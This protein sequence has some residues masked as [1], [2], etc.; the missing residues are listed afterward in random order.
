MDRIIRFARREVF[1]DGQ[2]FFNRAVG[3]IRVREHFLRV[4]GGP[5]KVTVNGNFDKT[6]ERGDGARRPYDELLQRRRR[7]FPLGPFRPVRGR[8]VD[9][10]QGGILHVRRG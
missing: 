9:E 8:H 2:T 1:R 10:R 3:E 5:A 4:S 7:G 6:D